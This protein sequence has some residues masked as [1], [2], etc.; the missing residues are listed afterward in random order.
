MIMI[1]I[2]PFLLSYKLIQNN[3]YDISTVFED[4][5][6]KFRRFPIL[7]TGPHNYLSLDFQG[8]QYHIIYTPL[9]LLSQRDKHE[10]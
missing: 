6:G 1:R 4:A 10:T 8:Y 9:I 2:F 5:F 7:D 3:E